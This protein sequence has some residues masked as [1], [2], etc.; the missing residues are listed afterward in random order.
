MAG[1]KIKYGLKNVYYAPATIA[2]DGTATY[3]TP[4]AIPGAVNLSLEAQGDRSSFYADDIEYYTDVANNGYDG[5]LEIAIVPEAFEKDILGAI[6]TK[7]KVL[8]EEVDAPVKHFA[9]LF[10]FKG[11]AKK[12]RHVMYNCTASRP[13]IEG[14]TKS[15]SVEPNTDTLSLHA[16]SVHNSKL[17]KDITK[18]KTSSATTEAIYNSWFTSVFQPTTETEK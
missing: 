7:G 16:T 10:E 17:D 2:D 13:A 9:L 5:D 8:V 1:N 6:E 3:E 14:E 4:V 18:A 12:I 11:D 15:E